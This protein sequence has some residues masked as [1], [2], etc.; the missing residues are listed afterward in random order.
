MAALTGVAAAGIG[1]AAAS[2]LVDA[3]PVRPADAVVVTTDATPDDPG[4]PVQALAGGDGAAHG[5]GAA[6]GLADL[7]GSEPGGTSPTTSAT[8]PVTDAP[9]GP[10]TPS[11]T[12]SV[13]VPVET[14][15]SAAT[16]TA[17]PR[18]T[19][20]PPGGVSASATTT[21]A[22]RPT[23]TVP[24]AVATTVAPAPPAAGTPTP[25]TAPP[26]V[27]TTVPPT[28]TTTA[29]TTVSPTVP[30][31]AATTTTAAPQAVGGT[32]ILG[33]SAVGDVVSQPVLPLVAR[34]PLNSSLPNFDTDR[35]SNPGLL[36]RK[37]G[38]LAVGDPTRLQRFRLTMPTVSKIDADASV[39][40]YAAPAVLLLDG[41]TVNV[42]L[43][44]CTGPSLDN[45]TVLATGSKGFLGLL[46]QY[47][48]VDITLGHVTATIAPPH[49]LELWVVADTS[50][51]RDLWLAYDTSS[52]SS[53]LT[54]V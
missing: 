21:T 28:V 45:C 3:R 42:A 34:P 24:R 5:G 35:D 15:A 41:M 48:A 38:A 26:T 16:T 9:A 37:G 31:T 25:A 7:S 10:S 47:Q 12:G 30:P 32:W 46:S 4:A 40:L 52:R 17:P 2:D 22:P 33:S 18:G 36:I 44:H 51:S 11:T 1:V 54:L 43:A 50:S 8:A 19:T 14:V 6:V 27:A 20:A 39:R 13:G 23:T 29:P 53:A 49:V